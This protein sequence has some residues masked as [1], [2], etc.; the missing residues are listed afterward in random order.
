MQFN[1]GNKPQSSEMITKFIEVF[2]SPLHILIQ[3]SINNNRE[4]VFNFSLNSFVSNITIIKYVQNQ[5][6][7]QS[8]L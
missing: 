8:V 6:N 4:G 5:I 2:W 3:I 7:E 1:K